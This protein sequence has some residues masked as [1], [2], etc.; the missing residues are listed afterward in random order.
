MILALAVSFTFSC[1]TKHV[2]EDTKPVEVDYKTGM[3]EADREFSKMSE[4]EGIKNALMHYIDNKGVLLRPNSMPLVGGNAVD[5]I[6]QGN[7]TSYTMTW[8][9]S[10]GT[11]AKSGDLG[12]TFGVYSIKP[13]NKDTVYYGTYVSVWKRQEDGKWKFVLETGNY[14]IE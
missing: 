6:S 9:P 4:H 3:I 10:G 11:V 7:D 1:N 5:Y 2:E 12:Y 13:K 8:E 14:G